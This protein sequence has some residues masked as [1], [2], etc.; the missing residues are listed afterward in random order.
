MIKN[1]LQKYEEIIKYLFFGVITTIASLIVYYF[2]VLTILDPSKSLELQIANVLSWTVGVLV[3]FFTNRK[4]VFK[5]KN[6]NK[7]KEF[8]SFV[9][10]RIFTLILDMVVMGVGVSILRK[11][12]KI[13]K[14]ISQIIVIVMN[15]ILSKIIIFK[16]ENNNENKN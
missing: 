13:I 3:A 12:D 9:L 8:I 15:Y 10:S 5:S 11:N 7:K 1:M 16:Q 14:I 2:L 6:K 4:Y